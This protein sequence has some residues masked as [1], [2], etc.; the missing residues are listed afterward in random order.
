M[1]SLAVV[2]DLHSPRSLECSEA[3]AAFQ[4]DLLAEYVLARSAHG[5]A[6]ATV[7]AELATVSEFLDWAGCFA[8]E[9]EPGHGDRF[10]AVD[11]RDRAVKTRQIKAGRIAMFYRFLE[12]RY[13]GEIHRLTGRVVSSPIDA[14]NRPTCTGPCTVRVPPSPAELAGFFARW[15]GELAEAR[16]WRTATRNYAM[17]RLA[18][19]VGLRATELCELSLDD[20]HFDHGP[21]GKIHV[22]MGKGS[23]GSGP[24]ER[25]V[26]MLGVAG[27]L[28]RWWVEEVRGGFGDD[29]ERP[30][31]AL[32]PSE[33]GGPADREAFRIAVKDAAGRH[34]RGGVRTLTPHVLRHACA[35]RLYADG[36]SLLAVQQV[37]GHRWLTTA[38]LLR[39]CRQRDDRGRIRPGG[40]AGRGPVDRPLSR[41]AATRRWNL[42]M[43]A[44]QQGVWKASDLRRALA[45][46]GLELS[47]GKM[48]HLWSQTP[49]SVRLDDLDVICSVLECSPSDLLIPE[50]QVVER[51][52][53]CR[54][55]RAGA[56]GSSS[57]GWTW[58][59]GAT[60]MSRHPR[61]ITCPDC[62]RHV[63]IHAQG[64][65]AACYQRRRRHY[66]VCDVCGEYRQLSASTCLR[67]QRRRRAT[68]GTCADCGRKVQRLWTRRCAF[69]A[70]TTWQVGSC[71]DCFAWAASLRGGRCR[72]CRD[73]S[74][75]NT[76]D[77]CRSC[78]RRLAVDRHGRCRLCATA[79]RDAHQAGEADWQTEP[80]QRPG[81][82][83]F[84][85]DGVSAPPRA[86]RSRPARTDPQ[87]APDSA[88]EQQATEQLELFSVPAVP[89]RAD[90]AARAWATSP[91][92]VE[93]L[94]AVSSFARTRGWPAATTRGVQR[95]V[96]L[97]AVTSPGFDPSPAVLAELRRR[98]LPVRRLREFLTAAE[99]GPAPRTNPVDLV[100]H[101]LGELP[102]AIAR[103]LASWIAALTAV[104]RQA[105]GR[106][107]PPNPP[108]TRSTLD[109]YLR[110][111]R[112][113]VQQWAQRYPSLRQVTDDDIDA[114][115]EP[116][117]GSRRTHTAVALRSLF[118]TL[119]AR[120]MI[121]ANPAGRT[122]PG[123]F[124]SRPVLGLDAATRSA[125]LTGLDRTDH[126]LVVLLLAAVHALPRADIAKLRLDDVDL[127]QRTLHVRGRRR[128]IDTL[129]YDHLVAWL[130]QRHQRWPNTANPHLLITTQSALNLTPVSTAYFQRLPIP[131]AD[132]RA[133]RL[134]AEARDTNGDVLALMH[135]F[136]LSSRGAVRYCTDL[137]P[138]GTPTGPPIPLNSRQTV[139][140]NGL[141]TRSSHPPGL[142]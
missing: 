27:T 104:E 135:L 110:A 101:V 140:Q 26:P 10:L 7:R 136:G 16:K 59:F 64:R 39:P 25:L 103:E 14:V 18:A 42:R 51:D 86:S 123:N 91:A 71:I 90:G 93:N 23:R 53:P 60:G 97:V 132:L 44:A 100:E 98:Y 128:P 88:T 76:Q 139:A 80:G 122:R 126:R 8:W 15:R 38:G 112:P 45:E 36:L 125:L 78:H 61:L 120:R 11:Q 21:L 46:A 6:D 9:V 141:P 5:A 96:A 37:L 13:Q 69:C 56:H 74:R 41:K 99:L 111:V 89:D 109:S 124:P 29:F 81:I 22:R 34:L 82:Q 133:D 24:R 20:L 65:C 105:V 72:A 17:A 70:H 87:T 28:L 107:E 12:V 30:R 75:R 92:G 138:D 3:A 35:S 84:L 114:H 62:G 40:G 95:A 116:L 19:E 67:C 4:E 47:A 73:F 142:Q 52:R 55:R 85:G 118:R 134:L 63:A 121:F 58:P 66:A 49:I 117:R 68:A 108:H 33:R 32:F 43:V 94:A 129:T 48:S 1:T 115:L 106:R 54:R 50:P 79:R 119:K 77:E 31:A 2:Q 57:P 102:A 127:H 137:E 131:V 130:H 83:L 113:A